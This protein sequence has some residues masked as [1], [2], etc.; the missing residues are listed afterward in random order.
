MTFDLRFPGSASTRAPK[1]AGVRTPRVS[2]GMP[3]YNGERFAAEAIDS[4][5]RQTFADFELIISDNSSTDRT[6]HICRAYAARDRR[7]SYFRSAENVGAARNV[8]RV[9]ELSSAP[10]FK[11]AFHDD[12]CE[13]RFLET[14]VA[15]LDRSPSVVLCHPRSAFIDEHGR[16]LREHNVGC[17]LRS[18]LP[19]DRARQYL[20]ECSNAFHPVFGL[21]RRTALERTSLIA[22][23]INSDLVLI[24]QL[25]LQGEV[26]EVADQLFLCRDF[27]GRTNRRYNTYAEMVAWHDPA[28]KSR[29]QFPCW[30]VAWELARSIGRAKLAPRE[31]A[32]CYWA[33]LKWCRWGY[34]HYIRE[35]I[36]AGRAIGPRTFAAR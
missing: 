34:K 20:L 9:F 2:V 18:P 22:P 5:L 30:R 4:I 6:E 3:V 12:I 14:C 24:L 21:I 15:V 17:D 36:Y 19:S 35:I 29:W 16:F 23:Y 10:Y 26:H 25:A 7:V 31:A 27:P 8:R 33:L 32:A 28:K 13:P 1:P 11:W